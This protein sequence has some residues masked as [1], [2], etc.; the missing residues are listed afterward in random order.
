MSRKYQHE[1]KEDVLQS[2]S[3]TRLVSCGQEMWALPEQFLNE[4]IMMLCILGV[5]LKE[6]NQNNTFLLNLLSDTN[7]RQS[8]RRKATLAHMCTMKR[9]QLYVSDRQCRPTKCG[10][11][12]EML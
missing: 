11:Y 6:K 7:N 8:E 5:A 12:G 3:K 10:I 2:Y 4:M 9:G 1:S